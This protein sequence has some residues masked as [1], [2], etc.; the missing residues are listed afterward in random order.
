MPGA[1]GVEV[2]TFMCPRRAEFNASAASPGPDHWRTNPSDPPGLLG[3]GQRACSYCGS[4]HPDDLFAAIESGVE[5]VPTDKDYKAYVGKAHKFYFQHL[6]IDQRKRFV[7]LLNSG[8]M[9]VGYP[10]RF[11]QLPFFCSREAS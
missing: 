3:A 1:R 7:E 10:G 6:S 9:K 11:Y 5:I 8:T 2:S 4:A